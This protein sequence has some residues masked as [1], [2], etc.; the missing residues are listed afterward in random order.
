MVSTSVK[1]F[2]EGVRK[3]AILVANLDRAAADAV[4]E[5]LGPE[6][7]QQVRQTVVA[8]DE[9]PA[10]ELEQ[11]LEE[12]AQMRPSRPARSSHGVELVGRLAK[13]IG[14]GPAYHGDS[15][16][17]EKGPAEKPFRRL[18]EAEG[19]KIARV[20]AGE[21]PQT[22]ALV[23]SHLSPSQAGAVLV[24]FP[25]DLQVDVMRR[26]IDLDETDPII[27]R[28]VEKTIEARLSELVQMQRRRVAGMEALSGILEESSSDVSLKIL[29]NLSLRDRK[30]A[31]RLGPP[32]FCFEDL[33]KM[34]DDFLAAAFRSVEPGWI[35]PA[36]L[37]AS[38]NL[39]ERALRGLPYEQAEKIYRQLQNPGPIRLSD[40]ETARRRIAESARRMLFAEKSRRSHAA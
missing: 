7:A 34:N 12:F 23:L 38:P 3:A 26:L 32:P 9:I 37:G 39:I 20:L 24:Q 4:L 8:M 11:V 13:E 18:R 30:L 14:E 21:R 27:L 1:K 19:E 31:Q 25:D 2:D 5:L 16:S 22:I 36:L 40:V 10:D 17:I 28:E 35:M 6:K 15:E 33:D 29:D